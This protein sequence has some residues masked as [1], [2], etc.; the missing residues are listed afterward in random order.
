MVTGPHPSIGYQLPEVPVSCCRID[1]DRSIKVLQVVFI[2]EIG[3]SY[4]M[5]FHVEENNRINMNKSIQ[6][7]RMKSVH[8]YFYNPLRDGSYTLP[9]SSFVIKNIKFYANPSQ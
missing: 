5:L 8:F 4:P 1:F 2:S 9:D 7:T 6:E 3:E